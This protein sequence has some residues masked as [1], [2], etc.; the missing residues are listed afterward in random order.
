MGRPI[1]QSCHT[2][3]VGTFYLSDNSTDKEKT[4]DVKLLVLFAVV[5][6][7]PWSLHHHITDHAVVIDTNLIT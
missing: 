2:L 7:Q 4:G 3:T 1:E 6:I 5:V